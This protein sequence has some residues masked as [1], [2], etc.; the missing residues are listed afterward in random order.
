MK[1]ALVA[2][3]IH[4]APEK[5]LAG[6]SSEIALKQVSE[7]THTIWDLIHHMSFWQDITLD[8]IDDKDVDWDRSKTEN[9]PSKDPDIHQKQLDQKIQEFLDGVKEFQNR[10]ESVDLDSNMVSWPQ[11]TKIWALQMIAQHNS[12][13]LG[14]III[15]RQ[16]LG[17]W[18][19][20]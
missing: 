14:Q 18:K 12:Y 11:G 6:L 5:I 16:L 15:L 10:A 3:H 19:K 17:D 20:E 9:W 4:A 1:Q 2:F 8:A 13:H 7:A